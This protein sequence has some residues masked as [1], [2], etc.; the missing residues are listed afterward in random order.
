M[1]VSHNSKCFTLI[2]YH[3]SHKQTFDEFCIFCKKLSGLEAVGP[4][5]WKV[6]PTDFGGLP[7]AHAD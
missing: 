7:L 2:S 3:H 5:F 6:N 4:A 1:C